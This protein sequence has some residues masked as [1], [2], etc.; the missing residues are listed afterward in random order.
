M[1]IP[2]W[3]MNQLIN[4]GATLDNLLLLFGFSREGLSNDIFFGIVGYQ[5]CHKRK[6][7]YFL[8]FLLKKLG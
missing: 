4:R 1:C 6:Y 2:S 5:G 3:L 8:V 7:V